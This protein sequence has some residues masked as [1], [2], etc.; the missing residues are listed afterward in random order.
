MHWS[1]HTDARKIKAALIAG[2][3]INFDFP[4]QYPLKFVGGGH[5]AA[6]F[7]DANNVIIRVSEAGRLDHYTD[8]LS[9]YSSSLPT[10]LKTM[11]WADFN[12]TIRPDVFDV[13]AFP[14]DRVKTIEIPE[15]F[16]EF[17]YEYFYVSTNNYSILRESIEVIFRI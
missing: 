12:I 13:D 4:V 10:I 1:E 9:G 3:Q 2:E 5:N 8:L 7:I 16:A 11:T 15:S 14:E 6:C 17:G